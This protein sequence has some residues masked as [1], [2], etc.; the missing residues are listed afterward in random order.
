[1]TK[2]KHPVW[3]RHLDGIADEMVRL[4]A[5]CDLDLRVPGAIERVLKGDQSVCGK[6]NA[7]AFKK[8]QRLLA[9]TY[10][11]LNKAVGRIG[12]DQARAITAEI[13]GRIDKH[14]AAGGQKP[15]HTRSPFGDR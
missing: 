13:I 7:I 10:G 8:L 15:G 9:A 14:R 3:Q 2:A 12:T 5:I 1:M 4:T 11:S 6:K